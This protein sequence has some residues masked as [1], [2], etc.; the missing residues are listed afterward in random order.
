MP[1][2]LLSKHG[3]TDDYLDTFAVAIATKK[4]K[5]EGTRP[6]YVGRVISNRDHA[7]AWPQP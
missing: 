3:S 4:K 5:N 6:C 7:F 2:I 1:I